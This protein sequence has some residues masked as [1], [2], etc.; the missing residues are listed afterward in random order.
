M[1]WG[2]GHVAETRRARKRPSTT[3]ALRLA[4]MILS[5]V[6][7]NLSVLLPAKE[8]AH[9]VSPSNDLLLQDNIEQLKR[10]NENLRSTAK[11]EHQKHLQEIYRIWQQEQIALSQRDSLAAQ[12]E[13]SEKVVAEL[14][15]QLAHHQ[16]V[17][18]ERADPAPEQNGLERSL[19]QSGTAPHESSVAAA[20]DRG[21]STSGARYAYTWVIGGIDEDRPAYKGFLYDVLISVNLLRKFGSEADFWLLAQLS[22]SAAATTE[23]PAED[24]RLL[25][26]MGVNVKHLPKPQKSSFA[27]LVYEKFHPLQFTQYER[28]MVSFFGP[29]APLGKLHVR[30]LSEQK[31]DTLPFLT[32]LP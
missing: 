12:L 6:L 26:A 3:I 24:V 11:E 2:S 23:L 5:V 4:V 30:W 15:A 13:G 28:V 16:R 19:N 27:H 10:Q 29:A 9:T 14:R 1:I 31:S 20:K 8:G 17:A 22:D 7:V 25:E 21:N 18:E 32:H